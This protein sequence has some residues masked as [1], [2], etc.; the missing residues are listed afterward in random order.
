MLLSDIHLTPDRLR[1]ISAGIRGGVPHEFDPEHVAAVA[2]A[3]PTAATNRRL[4]TV[5]VAVTAVLALLVVGLLV[6]AALLVR[7]LT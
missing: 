5:I 7:A 2:G 1:T 3:L 6:A 4:G